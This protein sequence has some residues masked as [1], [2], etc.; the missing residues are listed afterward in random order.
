MIWQKWLT[1]RRQGKGLKEESMTAESNAGYRRAPVAR[2]KAFQSSQIEL[3]IQH[4]AHTMDSD[5]PDLDAFEFNLCTI[6]CSVESGI[7]DH[8]PIIALQSSPEQYRPAVW[9]ASNNDIQQK[10][11]CLALSD[12]DNA[13]Y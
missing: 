2:F 3:G 4:M 8:C 9:K 10:S 13:Q 6:I 7:R 12:T 5:E 1:A 11:Q